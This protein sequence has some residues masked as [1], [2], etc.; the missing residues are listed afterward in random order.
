MSGKFHWLV[1]TALFVPLAASGCHTI[2]GVRHHDA[3]GVSQKGPCQKGV[4]QKG[5]CGCDGGYRGGHLLSGVH[6]LFWGCNRY[7]GCGCGETYWNEW[8]YDPPDC[9]DPCD[10]CYGCYVGPRDCCKKKFI[11]DPVLWVLAIKGKHCR[12]D[13]WYDPCGDWHCYG[14]GSCGCGGKGCCGSSYGDGY[15]EGEI[16]EASGVDMIPPGE[17]IDDVP[18]PTPVRAVRTGRVANNA[19]RSETRQAS[20]E[21]RR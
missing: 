11:I 8:L 10:D 7:D 1:A 19:D 4:S 3:C 2:G 14:D 12:G 21:L 16:F 6:G 20:H 5:G 17:V 9:C 13:G 15:M 18:D